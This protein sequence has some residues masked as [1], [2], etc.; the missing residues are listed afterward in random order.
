MD[1]RQE[2]TDAQVM[3]DSKALPQR[4]VLDSLSNLL[5]ELNAGETDEFPH[6]LKIVGS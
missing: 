2:G 1:I 5:L 3:S 4:V 6:P